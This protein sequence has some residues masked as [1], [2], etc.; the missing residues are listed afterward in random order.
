MDAFVGNM[1]LHHCPDSESAIREMTRVLKPN[2]RLVL[3]DMEEHEKKWLKDEMADLWLGFNL[4]KIKEMFQAAGLKK[5]K[6]ELL[7]TKCCGMSISGR[8][9]EIGIFLVKGE[10]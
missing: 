3:A 4:Q 5:V 7:R 6:A 2:G 10:K 8:K 1:V 9:A